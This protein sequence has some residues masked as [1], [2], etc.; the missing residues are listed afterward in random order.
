MGV[1]CGELLAALGWAVIGAIY[2][3]VTGVAPRAYWIYSG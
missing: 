2:Y 3:F 1:I